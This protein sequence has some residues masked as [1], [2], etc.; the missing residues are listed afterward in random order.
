MPLS[1]V[2]PYCSPR[3]RGFLTEGFLQTT[4]VMLRCCERSERS[5]VVRRSDVWL[6]RYPPSSEPRPR[7]WQP[8]IYVCADHEYYWAVVLSL[9]ASDSTLG[10]RW[11]FYA[12]MRGNDRPDKIVLYPNDAACV[13]RTIERLAPLLDGVRT[14]ALRHAATPRQLGLSTDAHAGI[15]VASDPTFLRVSWRLYRAT[16]IA[17]LHKNRLAT[18]SRSGGAAGW[19]RA[20]NLSA[21]HE[22]PLALSPRG[23]TQA[24]HSRW[25]E[26]L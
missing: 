7:S 25:A 22:G 6:C 1:S 2:A 15:F 5:G 4:R 20:M 17:W 16:C 14:H 12:S 18:R 24:I 19:K 10:V 8:K 21:A 26:V 13:K 11:K 3:V 23:G 9:L